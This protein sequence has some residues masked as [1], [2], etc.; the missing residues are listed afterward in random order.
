MMAMTWIMSVRSLVDRAPR[1]AVDRDRLAGDRGRR[2]GAEEQHHIGDIAGLDKAPERNL[3]QTL[4]RLF[5]DRVPLEL[6]AAPDHRFHARGPGVAR[7]DRVHGDAVPA[8]LLG[9]VLGEV[10]HPRVDHAVRDP[11]RAHVARGH[12]ADVD[13]A[14]ARTFFQPGQRLA[15]AAHVAEQLDVDMVAPFLVRQRAEA[16][17]RGA[18]R[19]VDQDVDRA[20]ARGR[21]GDEARDV[22]AAGHIRDLHQ[23]LGAERA[24]RV[25]RGLER[26]LTARAEGELRAL[27]GER[28]RDGPADALAAAGD[29]RDA[30]GETAAHLG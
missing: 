5:L 20:E 17:L 2:L 28:R 6:G 3:G 1:A 10:A 14:P 30:S 7:V 11:I 26:L 27:L 15:R 29:E 12:A 24:Q 18:D 9:E 13:D 8:D 25:G 4:A 23:D 21:R 22:R 16:A 19:V